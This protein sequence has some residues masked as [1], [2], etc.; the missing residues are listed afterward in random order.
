MKLFEDK[1][2]WIRIGLYSVMSYML[3][4]VSLFP[5]LGNL[6]IV[7][8]TVIVANWGFPSPK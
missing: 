2:G 1:N 7:I 8:L 4:Y 3:V 5:L 6:G